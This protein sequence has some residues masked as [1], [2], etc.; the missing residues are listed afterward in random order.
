MQTKSLIVDDVEISSNYNPNFP[1]SIFFDYDTEN[2]IAKITG[3]LKNLPGNTAFDTVWGFSSDV[4]DL[5]NYNQDTIS[6]NYASN[7]DV[8]PFDK[9]FVIRNGQLVYQ[10]ATYFNKFNFNIGTHTYNYEYAN[11]RI[12]E[13]R[14]GIL[15]RIF[16]LENG[17]LI[18]MEKLTNNISGELLYREIYYFT[19]YDSGTNF[20]KGKFFVSGN[21][22]KAFSNNNCKKVQY[23]KLQVINGIE[24]ELRGYTTTTIDYSYNSDEIASLFEQICQ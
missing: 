21:F 6:M 24:E 1:D 14:D 23:S 20:M 15:H 4:E 18:K 17:N 12:I 9:K 2:R 3:G 5:V 19:N 13:K 22:L 8:K 16:T 7:M 10:K 11:N